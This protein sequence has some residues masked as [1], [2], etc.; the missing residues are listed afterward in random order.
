M[1]GSERRRALEQG[2]ALLG[3]AHRYDADLHDDSTGSIEAGGVVLRE[4]ARLMLAGFQRGSENMFE[5]HPN[6]PQTRSL[7][8]Q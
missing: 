2:P 7:K 4:P 8:L 3:Y 5:E 1:E 6:A